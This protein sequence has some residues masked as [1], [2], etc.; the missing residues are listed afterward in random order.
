FGMG[1]IVR[2][3]EAQPARRLLVDGIPLPL[4]ADGEVVPEYKW[5]HLCNVGHYRGHHMGEFRMTPV[6][7]GQMVA[8]LKA[9]PQ[10]KAGEDGI[11]AANVI[12]W[13]YNHAS[14]MDPRGY[15]ATG[16]GSPAWTRD[17]ELRGGS[18]LWGWTWLG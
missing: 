2:L 11:G 9:H 16:A 12:P 7:F 5:I 1:R 3:F 15:A 6:V 4:P 10:F 18:Q 17:L 8:N 13:D 14:E